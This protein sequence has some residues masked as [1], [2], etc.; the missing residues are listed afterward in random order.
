[1]SSHVTMI[2]PSAD[3]RLFLGG[4]SRTRR[5]TCLSFNQDGNEGT[6]WR[7]GSRGLWKNSNS[8]RW[9][10]RTKA[11][12]WKKLF[13]WTNAAA[14]RSLSVPIWLVVP[15][16]QIK[17]DVT[18]SLV[19]TTS[20]RRRAEETRR[21][22]VAKQ[23][24]NKFLFLFAKRVK[25]IAICRHGRVCERRSA[26]GGGVAHRNWRLP[27]VMDLGRKQRTT[28]DCPFQ[29]SVAFKLAIS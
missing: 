7:C 21:R 13:E 3:L 22:V 26:L 16:E 15:R 25:S 5:V 12:K 27:H 6:R 19:R 11:V 9:L 8:A 24:P 2:W 1:M 23:G 28:A 20:D 14:N 29:C 17:V 18:L 4:G 10:C